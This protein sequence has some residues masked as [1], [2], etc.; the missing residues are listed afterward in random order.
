MAADPDLLFLSDRIEGH[1]DSKISSLKQ[2]FGGQ[3]LLHCSR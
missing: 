3:L 2:H 1:I